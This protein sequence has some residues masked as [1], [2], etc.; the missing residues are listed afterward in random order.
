MA[1]SYILSGVAKRSGKCRIIRDSVV[2]AD[3]SIKALKRYKDDVK[4]VNTGSE[5]GITF[6]NYT[7]FKEGDQLEF[8]EVVEKKHDK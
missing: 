1:G 5:C 7:D 6:D 3:T 8:Y 2:I 4:E